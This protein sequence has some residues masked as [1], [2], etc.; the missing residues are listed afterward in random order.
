MNI[1]IFIGLLF[2]VL[3]ALVS[4]VKNEEVLIYIF[5]VILFNYCENFFVFL[6]F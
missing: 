2:I 6:F 4:T 1:K 3:V 5:V